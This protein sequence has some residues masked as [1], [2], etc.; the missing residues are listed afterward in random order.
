M[1]NRNYPTWFLID[2]FSKLLALFSIHNLEKK[3]VNI[4]EK[5]G[6]K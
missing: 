4:E 2:D 1:Q 5:E 3:V 6:L